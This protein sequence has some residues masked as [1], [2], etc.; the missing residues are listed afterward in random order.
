MAV[1]F[2]YFN[3]EMLVA[4]VLHKLRI[5]A[6]FD[7]LSARICSFI[8]IRK[9]RSSFSSIIPQEVHLSLCQKRKLYQLAI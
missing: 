6:V 2:F 7:K 3:L 8:G 1:P 9:Q 4:E 5:A